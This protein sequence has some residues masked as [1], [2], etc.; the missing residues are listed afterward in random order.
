MSYVLREPALIRSSTNRFQSRRRRPAGGADCHFYIFGPHDRY[1]S[2][3]RTVTHHLRRRKF[4]TSWKM[5]ETLGIER[6]V[7]VNPTPN[8]THHQC[9]I[10]S[11]EIFGRKRAQGVAVVNES[12]PAGS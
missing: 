9:M 6:M 7:I 5:A 12:F 2:A 10:D 11:L 8:G 3:Q 1:P 4:D